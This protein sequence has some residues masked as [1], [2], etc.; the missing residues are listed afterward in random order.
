MAN[1]VLLKK[2]SIA[3]KAPTTQDLDYGELAL[4]Y[5]DGK[6]YYK[7][8]ANEIDSFSARA[9]G[10]TNSTLEHGSFYSKTTTVSGN[11]GEGFVVDSFQLADYRSGK[12]Q[13]QIQNGN[14]YYSCELLVIHNDGIVNTVQYA[15]ILM[16]HPVADISA[17]INGD[18]VDITVIPLLAD[19]DTIVVLVATLTRNYGSSYI[20]DIMNASG[21][22]DLM[23]GSGILDLQTGYNSVSA[24]DIQTLSGVE[25]LML[26]TGNTDLQ[27]GIV[28]VGDSSA[29]VIDIMN[30]TGTQ[31]LTLGV[32]SVDLQTGIGAL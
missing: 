23:L 18:N 9:T 19:D 14:G 16:G 27:A 6:L 24:I 28:Q 11:L 8:A 13:L 10:S 22:E 20:L 4:N 5:A 15:D 12:Y 25:D 32:G 7:N 26:E 2:S 3:S 29:Y 21:V 1:K 30:T 17:V 31:D